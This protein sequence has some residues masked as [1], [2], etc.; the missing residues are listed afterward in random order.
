MDCFAINEDPL[1]LERP[2]FT[3]GGAGCDGAT[4]MGSSDLAGSKADTG[5]I[6][7]M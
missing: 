1:T 7:T 3:S 4:S 5:V 2:F 6:D